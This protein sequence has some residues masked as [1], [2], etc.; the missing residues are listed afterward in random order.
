LTLSSPLDSFE[1]GLKCEPRILAV[2]PVYNAERL[3]V[4]KVVKSL[5]S[6]DYPHLRIAVIDDGSEGSLYPYLQREF[7]SLSQVTVLRNEKNVGFAQTLN[8]ALDL[9]SD[10]THLLVLEQDCEL[11]TSNYITEALKHFRSEK[12]GLVS[13]E[14]LLPP[15]E[16]LSLMKR[17]FVNHLSE[18]VHDSSVVEVGFS[19]LKADIFRVDVLKQIGGFESSAKWRFAC[20]EHLVSYK[21][22]SLGYTLIKD[23]DLRFRAYWGRQEK[24]LQNLRKEALYG[25]GLGWALAR[26]RSDLEIG[27]SEQLKSKMTTR[28]IQAQYVTL[29]VFSIFLLFFSPILA[30]IIIISSALLHL[31]Y[32]VYRATIF[33]K[34][35]EKILFIVTGFLRSWVYIPNFFLGFLYGF[36]IR[37]GHKTG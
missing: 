9:V 7:S 11:L 4:T 25:R 32:L 12:V 28:I 20:E 10:E 1:E 14:N 2:V 22:R 29:T 18:D 33:V 27:G 5:L 19:L 30:L 35:K 13:G 34:P 23:S 6:Q 21:I 31:F 17:I 8:K 16:Q 3:I 36:F 15:D 26:L 24:L 37:Y